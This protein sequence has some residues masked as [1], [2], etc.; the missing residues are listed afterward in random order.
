[1]HPKYR[2]TE[3][4]GSYTITVACG[5]QIMIV[6][7]SQREQIEVD[8]SPEQFVRDA[9]VVIASVF[10]EDPSRTKLIFRGHLLSNSHTLLYYRTTPFV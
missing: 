1:M 8:I 7:T 10:G 3:P 5:N 9:K 2:F 4:N 6:R